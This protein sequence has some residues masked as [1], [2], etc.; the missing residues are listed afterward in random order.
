MTSSN[1]YTWEWPHTK[2]WPKFSGPRVDIIKKM[3][4][5]VEIQSPKPIELIII[6]AVGAFQMGIFFRMSFAVLDQ[7][8][9]KSRNQF[10]QI[11]DLD[12]RL[13]AE[14]FTI[15]NRENDFRGYTI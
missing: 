13:S 3:F 10:T 4:L 5:A 15:V 14:F 7:A 8:T 9:A 2:K 6:C 1:E 11:S 12:P